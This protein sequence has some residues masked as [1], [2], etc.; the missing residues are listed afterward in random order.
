MFLNILKKPHPSEFTKESVILP[1][2]V[3]FLI[4][5]LVAP[6]EFGSLEIPNLFL[7]SLLF[8]VVTSATATLVVFLLIKLF[9]TFMY[10]DEWTVAKE[11]FLYIIIVI[12]IVFTNV[13]T[14]YVLELSSGSYF[15]ILFRMI[16]TTLTIGVFPISFLVLFEQYR[17]QKKQLQHAQRISKQAHLGENKQ[18]TILT[19][20]S[21]SSIVLLAENDKPELQIATNQLSYLKSDGNYVEVFYSDDYQIIQKKLIRNRLKTLYE[22]L[23]EQDFFHGHKSFVF[24]LHHVTE[25]RGNARNLE[26]KI[27][28]TKEW[29][30]ISRSKSEEFSD[31]ITSQ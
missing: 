14:V 11:I 30:P 26:V 12:C 21:A 9:P 28:S 23:P 7:Y 4:L 10:D 18:S 31:R 15:D 22:M 2:F 13:A 24:N 25:I 5:F 29:I 27:R 17:H 16:G 1:G 20:S 6:G 19:K 3:V 8:G